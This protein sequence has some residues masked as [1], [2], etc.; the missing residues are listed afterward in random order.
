MKR[1]AITRFSPLSYAGQ[2]AFNT[3]CTNLSFSGDQA[4][5][6]MITSSHAHE[7]K[8]FISM[9]I[10]RTMAK[11]GKRVVLLDVDLRRSYIISQYG[12]KREQ[13]EPMLGVV[14]LLAGMAGIEDVL[15]ATDI[16]NAYIVP[17]GREVSNP[18]PLL[19]SE[20]FGELL[21]YLAQHFDHVIVDAPP[22]GVVIDA[23]QIAKSCS[24]A[25]LTIAY[26][27]VHRKE[28][29]DAKRQLEQTGCPIVG[30]VLNGVE[31][32]KYA[33]RRYYY[34]SYYYYY[35]DEEHEKQ[36]KQKR[37]KKKQKSETMM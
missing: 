11:N 13:N 15:Y 21:E 32:D 33:N 20:R 4:K 37:K 2:E 3:L 24:G 8:S 16:E 36:H 27:E 6:L 23:A 25:L 14:H 30:T 22:I 7:G 10:L 26:N 18:L 35:G 29:L 28:L 5:R 19:N 31:V 9:N 34:K 12:L 17:I 1:L